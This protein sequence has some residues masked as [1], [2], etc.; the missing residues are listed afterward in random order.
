MR[1]LKRVG[2]IGL[3]L[4]TF[5]QLLLNQIL[6]SAPDENFGLNLRNAK[7]QALLLV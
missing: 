3:F 5:R 6:T 2:F 4:T 1:T 7:L